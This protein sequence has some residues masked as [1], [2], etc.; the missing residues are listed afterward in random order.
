MST[1]QVVLWM[2]EESERE[3]FFAKELC[4]CSC[5]WIFVAISFEQVVSGVVL[6]GVRRAVWFYLRHLE[7]SRDSFLT[8]FIARLSFESS[9]TDFVIQPSSIKNESLLT[10]RN[11][12]HVL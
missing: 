6:Y 3:Q 8:I 1:A 12:H 9:R 7:D 10:S 2:K 5:S 4:L 11:F